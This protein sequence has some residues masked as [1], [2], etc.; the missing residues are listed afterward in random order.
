MPK[1]PCVDGGDAL[2]SSNRVS[3]ATQ[4][5]MRAKGRRVRLDDPRAKAVAGIV[6]AVGIAA[7]LDVLLQNWDDGTGVLA[8][9]GILLA[10]A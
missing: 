1:R 2:R 3:V 6:L 7:V 8:V 9:A 10:A 4:V 5:A